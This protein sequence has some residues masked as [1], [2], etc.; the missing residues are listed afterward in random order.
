MV[1]SSFLCAYCWHVEKQW[2]LHVSLVPCPPVKF[3]QEFWRL[4]VNR[5]GLSVCVACR[6]WA[7]QYLAFP[8]LGPFVS[9]S[10]LVALAS[11]TSVVL[12]GHGV[13]TPWPPACCR[14]WLC[15]VLGCWLASFILL[16]G[17]AGCGSWFSFRAR[18]Q[19]AV[20]PPAW[21]AE[22]TVGKSVESGLRS[23][24]SVWRDA[25]GCREWQSVSSLWLLNKI[26]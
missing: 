26:F 2:R 20:S 17:V 25:E 15:T 19:P 21:Q 1:S 7:V 16:W 18:W 9:F 6:P 8:L 11:V 24:L 10:C 4:L 23:L 5:F 22:A 14:E 13:G 3:I 12:N